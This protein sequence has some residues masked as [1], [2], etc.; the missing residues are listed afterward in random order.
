MTDLHFEDLWAQAEA[1]HQANNK[2]NDLQSVLEGLIL[3]INLYKTLDSQTDFPPKEM[4]K[5]KT[6]T[7]GEILL[8][9]TNLSLKNDVNVYEA[10]ATALQYRQSGNPPQI[11]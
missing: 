11:A 9:M 5:I 8:T 1:F 10:L 6:R 2:D 4:Q 7:L 3:K